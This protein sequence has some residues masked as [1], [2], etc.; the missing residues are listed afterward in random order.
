MKSIFVAVLLL[1]LVPLTRA[2]E[3]KSTDGRYKAAEETLT[4]LDTP[5]LLKQAIDQMVQLQVQQNPTLAPYEAVMREFLGKY[6][7]WDSLKADLIKI[8]AEEFTAS[9]LAELN[10]FYQSPVG[11]KTVQKM[12]ALMTKG[13][14]IGTQR[15]Q[16]HMAELQAAVAAQERKQSEEATPSPAPEATE[17]KK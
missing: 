4:L 9:E 16:E 8:Y 12:P 6:M 3:E 13:A 7:S 5:N 1:I 10:R 2:A 11:K 17:Q 14:Q 15:V